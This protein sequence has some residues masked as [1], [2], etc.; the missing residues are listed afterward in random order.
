VAVVGTVLRA[1]RHAA[2]VAAA[3]IACTAAVGSDVAVA[4]SPVRPS[5]GRW[6]GHAGAATIVFTVEESKKGARYLVRPVVYCDPG[7]STFFETSL[8][9]ILQPDAWPITGRGSVRNAPVVGRFEVG[10]ASLR[11]AAG[12]T[13][14]A[15]GIRFTA[16]PTAAHPTVPD[17][18]WTIELAPHMK[19]ILGEFAT[20]RTRG[21]GATIDAD[22]GVYDGLETCYIQ[23]SPL[24]LLV[25]PNGSFDASINGNQLSSE[26]RT[27]HL[28]G[29]FLSTNTVR[30]TYTVTGPG[31]T[32]APVEFAGVLTS[33]YAPPK[34]AVGN[35]T[36]SNPAHRPGHGGE[37]PVEGAKCEDAGTVSPRFAPEEKREIPL[38]SF[39]VGPLPL[40]VS[41]SLSL[42]SVGL[43]QR[44]LE[45]LRADLARTL[46]TL[47]VEAR[48]KHGARQVN[49]MF[50]Y[51]FVPLGWHLPGGTGA[52][53][54]DAPVIDW[55]TATVTAPGGAE[56]GGLNFVYSPGKA[57]AP[58]FE[59]IKVP[60]LQE[61]VTLIALSH[62]FLSVRMG[63]E[64]SLSL[65]L[66]EKE[67]DKDVNEQVAEGEDPRA[68]PRQ[69][70]NETATQLTEEIDGAEGAL[71][72]EQAPPPELGADTTQIGAM[73]GEDIVTTIPEEVGTGPIADRVAASAITRGLL[74]ESPSLIGAVE[75]IAG[76]AILDVG[77]L[78]SEA[79]HHRPVSGV[80][81]I[82]GRP[83]VAAELR[84]RPI[85]RLARRTLHRAPFPAGRIPALIHG[86]FAL[87][88]PARVG[89]LAVTSRR[90]RPGATI[91]VVAPFLGTAKAHDALLTLAGPGYRATR[92]L[93]ITHGAAGA[94]IRLPKRLG[95]GT[96]TISAE[97]LSNVA[98]AAGG[99]SLS[100][101]A[102]LRIGVFRVR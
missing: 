76:P 13:C 12:G 35:V 22:W 51:T 95:R 97:D 100:G 57:I 21:E 8:F 65:Q 98:L 29:S 62:P 66:N 55:P 50:H 91:A 85:R 69:I 75:E 71:T 89:P 45:T 14:A 67:L 77:E 72:P 19:G 68:V 53:E 86:T 99:Q 80:H 30:G 102:I 58:E 43:C 59:L 3:W 83:P 78:A 18:D 96:W 42:G 56:F 79:A 10:S 6:E 61:T 54:P 48:Y 4:A 5:L 82:H 88:V 15:P 32:G 31:C 11:I 47:D 74:G 92:L 49:S 39:S 20:L 23:R 44:S 33:A 46:S 24:E 2:P 94:V 101:V 9:N 27:I 93:Q 28:T 60:V 81:R 90:L 38:G 40:A 36:L 63:P 1:L 87:A 52:H 25:Q 73:V 16:E 37:A 26:N 70:A 34:S 41:G 64:L 7:N 84:A 17:G